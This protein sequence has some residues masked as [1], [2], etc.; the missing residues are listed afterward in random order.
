MSSLPQPLTF[1]SLMVCAMAALA[2]D[3][4]SADLFKKG[5]ALIQP[6][7]AVVDREAADATTPQAKKEIAEGIR[8]LTEVTRQD[9]RNWSAFW[10]IGK[11]EQ[12]R[13]NHAAAES[14]FQRAFELNPE[15]SAV[16]RELMIESICA[17]HSADA[18]RVAEKSVSQNPR[19][20]EMVAN[21]A[22]AYLADGQV[23][24]ARRAVNDAIVLE[25]RDPITHA[26]SQEISAVEDGRKPRNYC[27]P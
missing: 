23:A 14:A 16:G 13:R 5:S 25:P 19:D 1:L 17:G 4:P 8:L 15:Q 18:V 27:P 9:P 3:P 20:P 11:G 21:L 26:L 7:M 22:L 10:I 24:K 2:G 12:A 6:Y